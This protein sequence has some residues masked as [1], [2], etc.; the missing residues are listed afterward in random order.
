MTLR[1]SEQTELPLTI[2]TT[3]DAWK[4]T[5]PCLKLSAQFFSAEFP[6]DLQICLDNS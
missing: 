5:L 2:Y 4:R 3:S 6:H 1:I